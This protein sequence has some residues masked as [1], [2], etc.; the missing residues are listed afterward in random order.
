MGAVNGRRIL[1][2]DPDPKVRRVAERA[3]LA[4]Q[5]EVVLADTEAEVFA[6]ADG[7]PF[8]LYM[9]NFDPPTAIDE[10]FGAFF[11]QLAQ[12]QPQARVVLHATGRTEDY[13]PLMQSRRH[14]RNLIA[15][16]D[17]PLDPDE[18]IVTA[19]KLLRHDLFGLDKYLM[20]GIEPYEIE[21]ADSREKADY[22]RRVADYARQ[23]GCNDRIVELVETMVDELVM[24]ALYNA[25]RNPDGS[26]R[27]A[28]LH[29][30]EQVLLEP[31]ERGTLSFA[32][33]GTHI[34]VA[35]SDPFGAL[36]HETIISYLNRCMVKGPQQM[37]D[38][39]GGAGLGLYRVFQSLTK[40]IINIQP[41]KRT[42]V[43]TL[44]DLRLSMKQFRTVP[45]SF[46]IFIAE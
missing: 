16:D 13:L 32:C 29:R 7:D 2:F 46:H 45:K 3:L 14:V 44:L 17:E 31:H 5:S 15:K 34:A 27:Y 12:K 35:Q 11:D 37:S 10:R 36:T 19:G 30:R 40:F 25:P 39:T 6:S 28:K 33:D 18:L 23:L 21:I 24:N 43:I 42:E 4:T 22:V 20:W 38:A 8:H 1:F 9:V 26:A 41:G